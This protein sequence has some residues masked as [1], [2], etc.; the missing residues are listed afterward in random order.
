MHRLIVSTLLALSIAPAF[1]ADVCT[2][3][4]KDKWQKQDA[5]KQQL[6]D[7]GYKIKTFKVTGSCYE[8][9]GWNKDKKKVEIYFNP[10]DGKIVKQGD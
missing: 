9:Y 3:A 6:L 4:P 8:I 1:A 2:D 10:V 5:F 7:Q